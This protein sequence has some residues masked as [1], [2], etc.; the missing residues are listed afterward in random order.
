MLFYVHMS[1]V[2]NRRM[3]TSRQS[4]VWS[5]P[6]W[7]VSTARSLP[8]V[9]PAQEKHSLWKVERAVRRDSSSTSLM[10]LGIRSQVELRGIIPSS[11]A[12]IF[13]SISH[14]TS[15]QFLVR[16][17]YL[18]IYNVG[19]R[20]TELK[21]TEGVF[22]LGKYPRSPFSRSKQTFAVARTP[23][24]RCSRSG[25][26]FVHHE[27]HARDRTRDDHRQP[28]SFNRVDHRFF[29]IVLFILFSRSATNMN[30]HSSR[31]HAIFV[32]TI[33]SSEVRSE[34][35]ASGMNILLVG[36]RWV[37]MTKHIFVWGN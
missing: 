13:D 7:K 37:R 4:E 20:L 24:R 35:E 12:H 33:E 27:K 26:Q 31:S 9:K 28:Q 30:E 19:V 1:L 16:A 32:I 11:F 10:R 21:S 23:E 17:S 5:I 25:S 8:T 22:L 18:E 34:P 2:P 3:S 15:Q 14:G 36:T 29:D 6:S